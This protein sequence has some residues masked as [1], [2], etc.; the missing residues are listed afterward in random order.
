LRQDVSHQIGMQ[1]IAR[2]EMS[3][4]LFW[5]G[6]PSKGGVWPAESDCSIL[7]YAQISAYS[8]ESGL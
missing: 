7:P 6:M 5:H 3:K 8:A 4:I 2:R 1:R